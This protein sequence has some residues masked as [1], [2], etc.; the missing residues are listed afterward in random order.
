MPNPQ[1][2]YILPDFTDGAEVNAALK[3]AQV[4]ISEPEVDTKLAT[5]QDK[6][7]LPQQEAVDS[8]ITAEKL[9]A[10]TNAINEV[11]TVVIE[12]I[13]VGQDLLYATNLTVTTDTTNYQITFQL[14]DQKGN[15]LGSARTLDLPIESLVMNV[16]YD[17]ENDR[18]VITLQNGT[19]TYIPVS[20]LV[21]GLQ[22]AI[23]PSN[24][25][26]ADLV[27]DSESVNKFIT[28]DQA[29]KLSQAVNKVKT[30]DLENVSGLVI[31]NGTGDDK[32]ISHSNVVTAEPTALFGKVAYDRNG[33]ITGSTPVVASDITGL[34]SADNMKVTGYS[35]PVSTAAIEPT[36][37][38]NEALGKLEAGLDSAGSVDSVSAQEDSGL[39]VN[40]TTGA[41]IID[42]AEGYSIPSNDKQG[43]WD[44]KVTAEIDGNTLKLF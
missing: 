3:K 11:Q 21:S 12:Q 16:E 10:I 15:N 9:T 27:D 32:I 4:S 28:T 37:T 1:N 2:V 14:T 30:Q 26:D 6:L 31:E 41:V 8:G 24:K 22:P 34:V 13:P 43:E 33:H 42:V 5:K 39:A 36:D 7:T 20:S 17:A 44:N 29:T 35:K 19:K 38:I 25:L 23:T 40:P 18:I